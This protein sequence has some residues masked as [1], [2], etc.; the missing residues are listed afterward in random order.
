M[1]L[2]DGLEVRALVAQQHLVELHRGL[3]VA[4]N[5]LHL[6][7]WTDLVLHLRKKCKTLLLRAPQATD[8]RTV[9]SETCALLLEG[10]GASLALL[11]GSTR[12][13][14][15]CAE[16]VRFLSQTLILLLHCLQQFAL[17]SEA[18][19]FLLRSQKERRRRR[20]DTCD[21]KAEDAWSRAAA[22]RSC[23]NSWFRFA[24]VLRNALFSL[25]ARTISSEKRK[26]PLKLYR[27]SASSS[28]RSRAASFSWSVPH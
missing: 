5:L 1:F 11:A 25:G 6:S 12:S 10:L 18:V 16:L 27:F 14:P 28:C 26:A 13:S 3:L 22:S 21:W 4:Q 20:R 2:F 8:R 15:F 23:T 24:M 19:Q 9:G 17:S 7:D